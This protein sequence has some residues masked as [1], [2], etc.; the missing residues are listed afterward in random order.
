MSSD[1]VFGYGSLAGHSRG[2]LT[3]LHGFRRDWGVAMDNRHDLPGYKYFLSEDESGKP[4]RPALCVAFLDVFESAGSSVN[5]VL[6]EIAPH[7]LRSLDERE[8]NYR[9]VDVSDH[10]PSAPGRVWVYAGI[11]ES[12]KRR[13]RAHERG[14]LVAQRSYLE[15][16]ERSFLALG[17]GQ[18]DRF[19]ESTLAV[20]FPVLD[21]RR[22]DL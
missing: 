6:I 19:R 14:K 11:D 15:A 9:R 2:R 5:G 8:R 16:V 13:A 12:R 4:I 20:D 10:V 21:L 1:F 3:E 17:D 18:L 7:D 22:V